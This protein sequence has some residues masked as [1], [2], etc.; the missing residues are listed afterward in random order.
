MLKAMKFLTTSFFAILLMAFTPLMAQEVETGT[1]DLQF[2]N[3]FSDFSAD[4]TMCTTLQIRSAVPGES[5]Y[6]GSFTAFFNYNTASINNPEY[7]GINFND[8]NLCAFDG[9]ASPYLAPAFGKDVATG[10]AN[11]TVI[12]VVPDNGCPIVEESW[13]DIGEV[14]F[15][16]I[17]ATLTTGITF[18]TLLT[19]IN[20][21][22]NLPGHNE[23]G[24]SGLD[25]TPASLESTGIQEQYATFVEVYPNPVNH[26]L[27]IQLP[28]TTT[29]TKWQTTIQTLDG[30]VIEQQQVINT[31]SIVNLQ[32]TN[33]STGMYFLLLEGENG[34]RLASRFVKN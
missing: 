25:V 4:P 1:Y 17:N 3:S 8:S 19:E 31:G 18:D 32:V 23:N 13:L 15:D 9:V 26:Q 21:N 5:F 30:K 33:L 24:L 29:N 27:A 10:E 6:V 2:A 28:N 14:C 7:Q 11:V 16:V 34:E 22:D 12:M 20:K